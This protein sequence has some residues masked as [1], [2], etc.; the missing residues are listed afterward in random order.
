MCLRTLLS[1]LWY[2][3]YG[4]AAVDL[5]RR[6]QQ[7]PALW[8]HGKLNSIEVI[9]KRLSRATELNKAE[10][11]EIGNQHSNQISLQRASV[12]K[13]MWIFKKTSK[14]VVFVAH[15]FWCCWSCFI[16]K[17]ANCQ[18]NFFCY[19]SVSISSNISIISRGMSAHKKYWRISFSLME[20]ESF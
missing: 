4:N 9:M 12:S 3:S 6:F 8:D 5:R 17:S 19:K 20:N 1:L 11:F 10:G 13:P 7:I 14:R 2:Q 15:C 16:Y 18:K